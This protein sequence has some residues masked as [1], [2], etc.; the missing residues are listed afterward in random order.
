MERNQA[1]NRNRR[2]ERGGLRWTQPAF[3]LIEMLVVMAIIGILAGLLLPVLMSSREE[4]RRA[5][6]LSNLREVG[7]AL[8]IY[9]NNSDGYLPS[10]PGYG[11]TW[12]RYVFGGQVLYNYPGH[13]GASRHM[14][15]GYGAEVPTASLDAALAP[16]TLS[17]MPVGLGLA[18]LRGD[19]PD[20]RVLLCPSMRTRVSTY[21]G[22]AEYQFNASLWDL[23]GG[24]PG[25]DFPLGD[26][27]RLFHTPVSDTTAVT[28][29]LGSY[30]YRDTPFYCRTAPANAADVPP[31]LAPPG[32][33]WSAAPEDCFSNIGKGGRWLAFWYLENT[34]PL[35]KAY[36][37]TPPFKTRR[38]LGDRAICSDSFDYA[39]PSIPDT[40]RTGEGL[41]NR[42][43]GKGYNVLY[44]DG[45]VSW[46]DDTT[47]YVSKWTDWNDPLHPG[48]DNLTISS[49]TSQKVWNLFDQAAGLDVP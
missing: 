27:R 32:G 14:V 1:M 23:L 37:M 43:H 26:G 8:Q 13:Q 47:G 45:H 48:S 21:Y 15:I 42:H 3:T 30:S 39:P 24:T 16:G 31:S 18:I 11:L 9:C 36:F 19:I 17:F 7:K 33:D 44:G 35:V 10:Y 46:Y 41:V 38:N 40:F 22:S 4:A 5:Q 34:K 29:L 20:P 2:P 28:A 25:E 6:C 12:C 49:P